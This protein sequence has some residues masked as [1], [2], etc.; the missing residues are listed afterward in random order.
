MLERI[1]ML[2][3]VTKSRERLIGGGEIG[4]QLQRLPIVSAGF[5]AASLLSQHVRQIEVRVRVAPKF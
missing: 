5:V 2:A 4:A 1:G 3:V